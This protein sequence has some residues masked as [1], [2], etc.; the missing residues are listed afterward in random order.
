MPL[1]ASQDLAARLERADR[2]LI[3]DAIA[4]TRERHPQADVFSIPLAGGLTAFGGEHSPLNKV[5]GLGFDGAP[6]AEA[7]EM[8]EQEYARRDCAVQVELSTL[9]N[10]EIGATLSK[11]GYQLCGHENV[12]GLP[13]PTP[14]RKPANDNFDLVIT[15][16]D[17]R[18][19]DQWLDCVVSGFLSVDAQGVAAHESFERRSLETVIDDFA[20]VP[21][22]SRLI[23]R[24]GGAVVGGASMRITD[25]VAQLCG[26]STLPQWRRRGAH[27]AMLSARLQ[28]AAESGCDIAI[29]TTLPGSKSQEN[30][31]KRGFELLY[32]RALLVREP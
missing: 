8:I 1:F 17:A 19:H 30:V 20:S 22:M 13:L 23:A 10:P 14:V 25:G 24:L 3:G 28:L 26:A 11:R 31:Q 4:T 2:T 15:P 5:V 7:L 21:G 12:L 27:S 29:V 32:S 18:E 16:V 6:S 9:A